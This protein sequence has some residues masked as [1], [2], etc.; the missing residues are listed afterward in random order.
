MGFQ[1]PLYNE[2]GTTRLDESCSQDLAVAKPESSTTNQQ[3]RIAGLQDSEKGW[4]SEFYWK[5]L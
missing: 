5:V 4:Q 2:S 1:E 3:R